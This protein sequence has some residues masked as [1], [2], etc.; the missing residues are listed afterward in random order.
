[1]GNSKRKQCLLQTWDQV[2]KHNVLLP[3]PAHPRRTPQEET[4]QALVLEPQVCT[5]PQ[6]LLN[7]SQVSTDSARLGMVAVF[8]VFPSLPCG[9][10]PTEDTGICSALQQSSLEPSLLHA[11]P[12][13]HSSVHPQSHRRLHNRSLMRGRGKR[14]LASL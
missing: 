2:G 7:C 1:M 3:Q 5:E 14:K 9:H 6:G 4:E 11:S 10:S 13:H 8:S 12:Q